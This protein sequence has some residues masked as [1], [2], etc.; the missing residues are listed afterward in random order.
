MPR[1]I[2][3]GCSANWVASQYFRAEL[4]V[5]DNATDEDIAAEVREAALEQFDWWIEDETEDSN[6]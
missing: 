4:E 1:I 6:K 3:W 2:K 5:D